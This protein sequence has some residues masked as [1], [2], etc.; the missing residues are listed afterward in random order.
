M[1]VCLGEA[2]NAEAGETGFYAGA[3]VA[4]IEP[5]V[6]MSDG[7][8]VMLRDTFPVHVDPISK[9]VGGSEAGWAVMLGYRISRNVAGELTYADFGAV[10]IQ[11]NYDLDAAFPIPIGLPIAVNHSASHIRGPVVSALGVLPVAQ[12]FAAFARVGVLFATQ[13]LNLTNG[14]GVFRGPRL[15]HDEELWV[16]GAGIDCDVAMRWSVRFEYQA[17]ER[18]P[19]NSITGSV[20]LDRFAFGVTYKF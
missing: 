20:R 16:L 1:L 8:T 13:E 15:K 5:T 2:A 19:A 11:E 18:L 17:V 12:G 10:D 6:G 14:P 9:T 4:I 7:L 3:D